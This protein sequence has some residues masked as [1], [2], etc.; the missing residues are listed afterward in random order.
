MLYRLSDECVSVSWIR[1]WGR[2][3]TDGRA[4]S[5][6]AGYGNGFLVFD[7]M[8][9]TKWPFNLTPLLGVVECDAN[10]FVGLEYDLLEGQVS[11]W[12]KLNWLGD[13]DGN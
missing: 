5:N 11:E 2:K 6:W 3:W 10:R 7:L 4:E 8:A 1:G 9:T 13:L 12:R